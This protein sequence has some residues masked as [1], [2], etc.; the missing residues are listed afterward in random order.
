MRA[1][2][3]QNFWSS[4]RELKHA[5]AT[6]CFRLIWSCGRFQIDYGVGNIAFVRGGSPADNLECSAPSLLRPR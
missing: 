3:L 5:G 2:L 4:Q 1:F 6:V